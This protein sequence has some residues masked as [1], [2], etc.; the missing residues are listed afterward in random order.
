MLAPLESHC[1]RF[2]DP[3]PDINTLSGEIARRG[4]ITAREGWH[5]ALAEARA[6]SSKAALLRLSSGGEPVSAVMLGPGLGPDGRLRPH[7]HWSY[8][9]RSSERQSETFVVEVPSLGAVRSSL[10]GPHPTTDPPVGDD[11]LDT[12]R[13]LAIC[14]EIWQDAAAG[15]SLANASFFRCEL[16]TGPSPIGIEKRGLPIPAAG[17]QPPPSGRWWTIEYR[18]TDRGR[19]RTSIA[20]VDA[21]SGGHVVTLVETH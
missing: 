16:R 13:L 8:L 19:V 14:T 10:C 15:Q 7:S 5:E 6:W 20:R 21:V 9:F 1:G 18:T 4:S 3:L 11:W 12:D 2:L 17:P